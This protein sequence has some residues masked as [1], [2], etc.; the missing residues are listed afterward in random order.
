MPSLAET[1]SPRPD[2]QRRAAIRRAS[3]QARL[4]LRRDDKQLRDQL[5][6]MYHR[7]A[8]RIEQRIREAASSDNQIALSQLAALRS[9]I[10]TEIAA[11]GNDRGELFDAAI[12]SAAN[13]GAGPFDAEIG[14]RLNAIAA[15]TV[16]FIRTYVEEDGLQLSERFWK[17][18]QASRAR[19]VEGLEQAIIS[20]ES[21]NA[22]AREFLA[23]G[24]A[25][26]P[27]IRRKMGAA[28]AEELAKLPGRAL[29]KG[30]DEAAALARVQMI[31]RTEINR[32]HGEAFRTAS[33]ETDGVIG[34]RFL[35]SANHPRP[36][37]CDMHAS[38]N[39]YGLGP[40][41]YP[42]DKSPWPAHPNTFSFE[43]PVFDD[44]V[45]DEDRAGQETRI[46]WLKNQPAR[47]QAAVL[48][49]GNKVAALRSGVLKEG[50]INT[51]WKVLKVRYQ[52]QGID[53]DQFKK[54]LD[55][56]DI[57][58]RPSVDDYQPAGRAVSQALR[59]EDD[60]SLAQDVLE[61]I[62]GVHGDGKLPAIPVI[63]DNY[64]NALGYYLGNTR[65]GV[66]PNGPWKA[67]T[68]THEIGHFLDHRGYGRSQRFSSTFDSKW[69]AWRAA[70]S[71]SDAIAKLSA[72]R[73]VAKPRKLAEY[74]DYLLG[75]DETWARSYAQYIT[76]RSGH[77]R[78]QDDLERLRSRAVGVNTYKQWSDEDFEP[79]A[80][81]MDEL[82]E[83]LKW[84]KSKTTT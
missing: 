3:R 39:R 28:N 74:L 61:A 69:A 27:E 25:V 20:G 21:A 8:N 80:Q 55:P 84:R 68:L 24:Q 49:S 12:T 62:D 53:I 45:T 66:L 40:G 56:L 43:E 22:A 44:E 48:G 6:A 81:A 7:A 67:L 32:A 47:T 52:R 65:I 64:D 50:Q 38:V 33:L 63:A 10:E 5:R 29:L 82:M 35:L 58:P 54:Q 75:L 79:I 2:A 15:D 46:D 83:T 76:L 77:P 34:M 19:I 18:D 1:L 4:Q 31:F 16:R 59:I 71:K 51:P 17:T 26:P 60:V 36:D 37:I 11:L 72:A 41:V 57:A 70:V 73:T 9:N 14:G 30:D 23:N 13:N 42:A 78:L